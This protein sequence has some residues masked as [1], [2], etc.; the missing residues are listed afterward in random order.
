MQSLNLVLVSK[1]NVMN[2]SRSKKCFQSVLMPILILILISNNF[3]QLSLWIKSLSVR[4]N[5][6]C[7]STTKMNVCRCYNLRWSRVV[8]LIF[9]PQS[10][11]TLPD[12]TVGNLDLILKWFT[13]R[14][15]DTNPSMLNKALEYLR[16]VLSMLVEMD[17]S[18]HEYEASSF[19]PY[20]II[21]VSEQ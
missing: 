10:L 9:F 1:V 7:E 15:L 20:L 18:L 2:Q 11:E 16:L 5:V 4:R 21:K 14:F 3:Q 13:V 19:I 17:Y 6:Q 8:T 12:E